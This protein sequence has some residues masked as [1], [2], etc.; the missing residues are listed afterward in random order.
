[1][2]QTMNL[3]EWGLLF[4]LAIIWG[5]SYFFVDIALTQLPVFSIVLL[6]VAGAALFLFALLYL[7]G[8]RMPFN[9]QAWRGMLCIGLLN[10][11]APFCLIVWGQTYISGGL[12]SVLIAMTPVFS[13]LVLRGLG[14]EKRIGAGKLAGLVLGITGVAVIIGPDVFAGLKGDLT[15]Q[16]AILL[17]AFSYACAGVY[18][19]RLQ[20]QGYST[21]VITAGQVTASTLLLLPAVLWVDQPWLLPL[22]DTSVLL[23]VAALALVCTAL[24]YIIY[25]RIL[26]TAGPTNL[27][28]VTF[29]APVSA[30]SLGAIFLGQSLSAEHYLGILLVGAGLLAIDGRTVK[31]FTGAKNNQQ[32]VM[33]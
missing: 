28:L 7:L 8:Q 1:M 18:G 25:F 13:I 31:L 24:A 12:A 22:P 10:N 20:G 4:S 14:I 16:L 27:L 9:W 15:A 11:A 17:A 19:K 2:K 33:K 5:G 21:L 26:S 32:E 3:Q 23:A 6:R 30:I 29:L